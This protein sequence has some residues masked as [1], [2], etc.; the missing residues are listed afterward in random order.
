MSFSSG[1]F[2][3]WPSSSAKSEEEAEVTEL[4]LEIE[5]TDES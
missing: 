1:G 5:K 2:H 3:L 4:M